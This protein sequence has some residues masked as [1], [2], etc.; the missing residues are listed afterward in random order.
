VTP[1]V[2]GALLAVAVAALGN[3]TRF[4]R[5]R[6]FYPTLLIII[7]SYYILFGLQGGST[8]ALVQEVAIAT[9]FSAVALFGALRFPSLVGIG[10]AVH[11]LFDLVHHVIIQNPGVPS[12]WPG[13]CMSV[14]LIL[15]FW[16]IG[17]SSSRRTDTVTSSPL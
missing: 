15:G 4:D 14:D 2:V 6:S 5:D 16:V 9:I 8:S 12:W 7:A 3:V 10:I 13:F 17:L 1:F 11:G